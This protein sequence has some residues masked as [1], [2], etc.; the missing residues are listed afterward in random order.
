[1][2]CWY[3]RE[4]L[5]SKFSLVACEDC[6]EVCFVGLVLGR[7]YVWC[8][9]IVVIFMRFGQAGVE[10]CGECLKVIN[11]H[12]RLK[13]HKNHKKGTLF[14]EKADSQYVILLY[15]ETLLQVLLVIYCN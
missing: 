11:C 15:C 7:N 1:M 9:D 12:K 3:V 5:E 10:W 14:I 8:L 2:L 13:T 6:L 4:K